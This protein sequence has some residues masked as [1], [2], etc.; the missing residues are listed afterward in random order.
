[1]KKKNKASKGLEDVHVFVAARA[2]W[3]CY[4]LDDARLVAAGQMSTWDAPSM[5]RGGGGVSNNNSI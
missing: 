4:R 3:S 2:I 5:R 1:M